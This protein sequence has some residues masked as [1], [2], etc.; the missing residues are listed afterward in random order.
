MRSSEDSDEVLFD[1]LKQGKESAFTQL[2]NRYWELL[3]EV[4]YRRLKSQDDA[5][6]CVQ[7]VFIQLWNRRDKISLIYS[8]KT[9]I[10]AAIKYKIYDK[11]LERKKNNM[12]ILDDFGK[13][14]LAEDA[15]DS[16]VHFNEL[17]VR[18]ESVIAQLPEKCQMVYRLSREEGLSA[19]QIAERL[20][21]NEKTVEGHLTKALKVLKSHFRLSYIQLLV[22]FFRLF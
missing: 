21:I 15:T 4:A 5:K 6:D 14:I 18:I 8:F 19:R 20:Q 17:R 2:Y 3:L 16:R 1:L 11:V 9:Y 13:S 12:L 22:I 7:Q 10:S